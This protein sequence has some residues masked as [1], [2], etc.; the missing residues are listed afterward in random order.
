MGAAVLVA[1]A[2]LAAPGAAGAGRLVSAPEPARADSVAQGT[3]KPSA[4]W[5]SP[6]E[7]NYRRLIAL[8]I[9]SRI[10]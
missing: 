10:G 5:S 4:S 3:W 2:A 1:A 7:L 6:L 9:R 8:S